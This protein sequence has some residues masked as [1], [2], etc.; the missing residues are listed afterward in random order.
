MGQKYLLIEK[1]Q[2][3]WPIPWEAAI[4]QLG[5]I[6]NGEQGGCRTRSWQSHCIKTQFDAGPNRWR[7][8]TTASP[9]IRHELPSPFPNL[10][11]HW[12]FC[13]LILVAVSSLLHGLLS[14]AL[15]C[16][17]NTPEALCQTLFFH[18]D[19]IELQALHWSCLTGARVSS[20]VCV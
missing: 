19:C 15:I 8:G 20:S 13:A 9:S 11:V 16:S 7:D 10:S 5:S 6:W 4:H 14:Y 18:L 3:C 17:E 2:L 12:Y 1:A